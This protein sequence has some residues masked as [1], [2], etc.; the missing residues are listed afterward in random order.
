MENSGTDFLMLSI[1]LADN[2]RKQ[3]NVY[4]DTDAEKLAYDFCSENNLD[5]KSLKNL[6]SQLEEARQTLI[7]SKSPLKKDLSFQRR[8][9][10]ISS[11]QNRSLVSEKRKKEEEK[12]K[13]ILGD[14][15][16]TLE[17]LNGYIDRYLEEKGRKKARKGG[18]MGGEE[19]R[20]RT[21]NDR[22][23]TKEDIRN[24][25]ESGGDTVQVKCSDIKGNNLSD[26]KGKKYC[27]KQLGI[28]FIREDFSQKKGGCYN[29]QTD[30]NNVCKTIENR[31]GNFGQLM[32]GV[33][34]NGEKTGK[35]SNIV[36]K[37]ERTKER[38]GKIVDNKIKETIKNSNNN[39]IYSS[40]NKLRGKNNKRTYINYIEN[41]DSI[42]LNK[43]QFVN[44][45]FNNLNVYSNKFLKSKINV[46]NSKESDSVLSHKKP[47]HNSLYNMFSQDKYKLFSFK[48]YSSFRKI[49]HKLDKD[50]ANLISKSSISTNELPLRIQK[51]ISPIIDEL[52]EE[53]ETLNEEEFIT[54]CCHLFNL[55]DFNEKNELILYGSEGGKGKEIESDNLR[56]FKF[57]P[58]INSTTNNNNINITGYPKSLNLINYN[59]EF[60]KDF[61]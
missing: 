14:A 43:D 3:I 52:I 53:N 39:I 7:S 12:Q 30:A 10:P 17:E 46:L 8:R 55:L 48:K 47:V 49:F 57:V 51:I 41:N 34:F 31:E 24:Y 58:F 40:N 22:I 5:Y 6:K 23:N 29:K 54:A 20:K 18:E 9:K 38:Y 11:A 60:N 45:S 15:N 2:E 50:D 28:N 35:I 32:D 33:N 13:K 44:K 16:R 61:V 59:Y 21:R 42:E 25:E 36:V 1:E 19:E 56:E 4:P 27:K 26:N 37:T